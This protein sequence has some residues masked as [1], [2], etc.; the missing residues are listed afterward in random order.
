MLT[1]TEPQEMA[2][3]LILRGE[4]V[5][6]IAPTGTGKTEAALLP[7][8]AR[9]MAEGRAAG[10]VRMLYVTPLRA[11][12]RDLMLRISW[13]ASR[14][15]LSVAVRH[16]DTPAI[17]RRAQLARPPDILVTTPETLQILLVARRFRQ[18]LASVR[19]LIVDEVHELAES[20][21]GAQLSLALEKLKVMTGEHPQIAGLSATVGS[22]EEVARF[23]GGSSPT[24][25]V[26]YVSAA[27]TMEIGVEYP[28]PSPEDG[29]LAARLYV[30]PDVAAR[31]R[32]IRELIREAKTALIFTNTRSMTEILGSR[33]RMWDASLA[34]AV[35]HGSL[36]A[37]ARVT[38]ERSLREGRVRSLVSTSSLELGIDVGHVDLV[39]QYMSPRQATRLVQRVGR[40]GH[41]VGE[42]SRGVV[43]VMTPDDALES[44]VVRRRALEDR[45]EAVKIP[46]KPYD[47]LLHEIVALLMWKPEWTV[48]EALGIIR[49]AYNYRRLGPE[50][51]L[52]LVKFLASL[53]RSPVLVSEPTRFRRGPGFSGLYPYYFENLS[54]IPEIRAYLVVDQDTEEPVG[55]LDEPFVAERGEPG[56]KFIMAGEVW[57]IV[58]IF[59]DRVYVVRDPDPEGAVPH[60]LGEEIPVPW[61]VSQEVGLIRGRV[62][63]AISSGLSR[64]EVARSLSRD[65]GV[66]EDTVL[67]AI[68]PTV[69]TAERGLSVPTHR[70]VV[71][72][73]VGNTVIV[74]VHAGTLANRAL[75][76]YLA[77]IAA[78]ETGGA[79]GVAED[80]YR[81]YLTGRLVTPGLVADGLASPPTDVGEVLRAAVERSGYFRFRLLQAARKMG[82]LSRDAEVT[83]SVLDR[84]KVSLEGTPVYRQAVRDVLERDM[85]IPGAEEV[86]GRLASG[87]WELVN[88]GRTAEPTPISRDALRWIRVRVESIPP[89]K[90]RLLRRERLRVKILTETVTLACLSCRGYVEEVEPYELPQRPECPL[91]GSRL[92]GVS[93][94]PDIAVEQALSL[95]ER[96]LRSKSRRRMRR[97]VSEIKMTARLVEAHGRLAVMALAAGIPPRAAEDILERSGGSEAALIDA[98][99][100]FTSRRR[101]R[102]R[103]G[104]G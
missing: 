44:M 2:I 43:I 30:T 87:D 92:L 58:Q 17:E 27:K 34:M 25:R 32:R 24:P 95:S 21:R 26:V 23:L 53:P 62:A 16:G 71:V 80:P 14:L 100:E 63:E 3:P 73:A 29:E 52:D 46:E 68:S 12:N 83:P 38:A 81:L 90:R 96:A 82:V 103:R 39:V 9:M 91:C 89:D 35:H 64:R 97:I 40:S 70:R 86:M 67:R 28:L 59:R 102:G 98:I 8:L 54:M 10:G 15:D 55:T 65:Y 94:E 51:L 93:R 57:R 47:A 7:M 79:V 75:A 76:R 11:L 4:N 49:R 33:L 1:P 99:L 69:E 19:Y 50:E 85:S 78:R 66:A 22:P 74:H 61:S 60:W 88:L 56:S 31:L 104:A 13:W 42:V 20:K 72:E 37:R 36:A 48:P 101:I 77:E 6:L 84:L 41:R 5:L 18:H 45:L